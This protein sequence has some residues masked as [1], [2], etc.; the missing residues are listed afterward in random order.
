MFWHD[1]PEL[2]RSDDEEEAPVDEREINSSSQHT[3]ISMSSPVEHDASTAVPL[4][5]IDEAGKGTKDQDASEA[6]LEDWKCQD[7]QNVGLAIAKVEET[8]QVLR[9]VTIAEVRNR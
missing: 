8:I 7:Q 2:E 5:D 1:A 3:A 4:L 9:H 6:P